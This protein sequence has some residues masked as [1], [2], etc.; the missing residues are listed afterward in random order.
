M[1]TNENCLGTLATPRTPM[2][3]ARATLL[4]VKST[5]LHGP[6]SIITRHERRSIANCYADQEMSVIT[7]YLNDNAQTP[8]NRFV[9]Y[10]YYSQLCNKYSDKS[11]RWNFV[12]S[13]TI[14]VISSS[15]SWATLLIAIHRVACRIFSNSTVVHTKMGHVSKTTPLLGMI[16]QPFGKT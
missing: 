10:M 2:D 12:A 6:P 15:P 11:N 9:V 8:L 3:R 14:G 1:K 5:I 7:T 16:C 13:R 4:H